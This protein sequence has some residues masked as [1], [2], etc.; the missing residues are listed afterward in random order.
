[1]QYDNTYIP[2]IAWITICIITFIVSI[3]HA[4]YQLNKD[5]LEIERRIKEETLPEE[6]KPITYKVE[7]SSPNIIKKPKSEN[8]F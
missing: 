6:N 1:M 4:N 5:K 7:Y 8:L 2:G 3:S